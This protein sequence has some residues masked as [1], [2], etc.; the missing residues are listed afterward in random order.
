MQSRVS[1]ILMK[2]SPMSLQ[3]QN[4]GQKENY[5]IKYII[6]TKQTV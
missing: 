1:V 3:S 4:H 6:V 5:N 2:T